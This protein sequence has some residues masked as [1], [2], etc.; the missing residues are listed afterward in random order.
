MPDSSELRTLCGSLKYVVHFVCQILV[1]LVFSI[2]RA[3]DSA[4]GRIGPG[5]LP[6]AGS[7]QRTLRAD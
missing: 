3:A 1:V 6:T 7:S 5:Q 2:N 4:V